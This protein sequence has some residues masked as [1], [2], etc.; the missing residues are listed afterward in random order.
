MQVKLKN[1]NFQE[2]LELYMS[3]RGSSR[4]KALDHPNGYLFID[5]RNKFR[6]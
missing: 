4:S 6:R 2:W 5:F 1:S 3:E